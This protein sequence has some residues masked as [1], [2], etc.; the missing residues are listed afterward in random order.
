LFSANAPADWP[1]LHGH[2]QH[3]G[4]VDAELRPPFRL[5]WKRRSFGENLVDP[6][7][8]AIGGFAAVA[9]LNSA[10]AAE[11]ARHVDVPWCR[12]DLWYMK[13]LAVIL[14]AAQ[15]PGKLGGAK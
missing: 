12:A 8:L 11:L 6:P 9:W 5:A 13:K 1:L 7:D 14:E 4:F 10:D 3:T 15:R 2:P